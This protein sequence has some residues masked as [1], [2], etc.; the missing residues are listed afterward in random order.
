MT[1]QHAERDE[2]VLIG[3][4]VF[5]PLAVVAYMIYMFS[6][7]VCW[8]LII[9]SFGSCYFNPPIVKDTLKFAI[10]VIAFVYRCIQSIVIR[11]FSSEERLNSIQ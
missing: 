6:P 1:Q 4:A 9:G 5:I 7:G 11:T 3:L 2:D 10:D 8:T